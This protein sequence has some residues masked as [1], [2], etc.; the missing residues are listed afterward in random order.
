MKKILNILSILT[1]F[2]L[3][4][5]IFATIYLHSINRQLVMRHEAGFGILFLSNLPYLLSL[6]LILYFFIVR[7]SRCNP[8]III[9]LALVT[10]ILAIAYMA[11]PVITIF[12]N[13]FLH[14]YFSPDLYLMLLGVSFIVYVILFVQE[15]NN[16][17]V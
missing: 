4:F 8:I 1:L 15:F 13:L 9:G 14:V 2:S 11:L 5:A 6:W 3:P 16:K 12:R 10:A 7:K 17:G